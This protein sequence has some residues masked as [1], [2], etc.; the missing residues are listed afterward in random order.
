MIAVGIAH[1]I[2]KDGW[3]N[4]NPLIVTQVR[5]G[6]GR[7]LKKGDFEAKV[8]WDFACLDALPGNIFLIV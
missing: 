1:G 5:H 7:I 6:G 2:E 4:M 8:G 3:F